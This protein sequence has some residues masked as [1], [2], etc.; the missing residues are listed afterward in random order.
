MPCAESS[1]HRVRGLLGHEPR[2][3]QDRLAAAGQQAVLCVLGDDEDAQVALQVLL[4]VDGEQH[5]AV[6]DRRQHLRRQ[7]ERRQHD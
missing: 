4:L 6:L 2:P 1:G 5:G 3:G 7:V